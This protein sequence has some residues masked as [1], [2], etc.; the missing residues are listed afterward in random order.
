MADL[1]LTSYPRTQVILF[2]GCIRLG[3]LWF[4]R[5]RPISVAVQLASS[6]NSGLH[7]VERWISSVDSRHLYWIVYFACAQ[8]ERTICSDS[9]VRMEQRTVKKNYFGGASDL[10]VVVVRLEHALRG[11]GDSANSSGEH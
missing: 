3:L 9:R 2:V 11:L 4:R 1:T 8:L 7:R 5:T 6:Q 10:V